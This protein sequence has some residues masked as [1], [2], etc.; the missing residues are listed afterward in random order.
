[1]ITTSSSRTG[2]RSTEGG[3]V[4]S[5][6]VRPAQAQP[7]AQPPVVNPHIE[8]NTPPP[9]PSPVPA[10][11]PS[12][13]PVYAMD[14]NETASTLYAQ[15]A[16]AKDYAAQEQRAKANKVANVA[17]VGLDEHQKRHG[18]KADAMAQLAR[19]DVLHRQLDLAQQYARA[20]TQHQHRAQAMV[21]INENERA[22]VEA[23]KAARMQAQ[24]EALD[25]AIKDRSRINAARR[26]AADDESRIREAL[27]ESQKIAFGKLSPDRGRS[28]T[29]NIEKSKRDD[30]TATVA[31]PEGEY[32]VNEGILKPTK[33]KSKLESE[34]AMDA[35]NT[36]LRKATRIVPGKT[37][38][39]A[40]YLKEI[41][42]GLTNTKVKAQL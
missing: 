20:R 24:R 26:Q 33:K 30:S 12:N 41:K 22:K 11:I 32:V 5:M 7:Y 23:E 2:Y 8:R 27:L 28:P 15:E 35:L 13:V 39:N 31:Y 9:P 1:V 21:S 29:R 3:G 38:L 40:K 10:N 14:Y 25:Q 4:F 16:V 17:K 42:Q 19:G 36:G 6:G 34:G 18:P 37:A